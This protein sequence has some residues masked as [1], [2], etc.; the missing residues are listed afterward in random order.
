[1]APGKATLA[2]VTGILQSDGGYIHSDGDANWW[3]PSGR[4][5][6]SPEP[7]DSAAQELA[8]ARGHFFLPSRFED[9][10][11]NAATVGY[12]AHDL[13]PAQTND[14]LGNSVVAEIDYRVLQPRRMTDPNGNRS[15]VSFDA[16]GMVVGTAVIGKVG[17]S[18]GD[19]LDGFAPDLHEPNL[20]N[21]IDHPLADPHAILQGATMRLGYDLFAYQRTQNDPQ[22]QPALVYTLARET[23]VANLEPGEKSKIQHGF[24]YSDGF[25]REI[26]KKIQAEPGP[27]QD[28]GPTLSPRWVG[29]GWT[30]FN[31]KSKP[32]RQYEP[33]FSETHRFEFAHAVGVSPVLFYDPVGRVVATLS[34]NHTWGKVVF[35]PW[36]QEAWDRSDTVSIANP[37]TDADVGRYFERLPA[38]DYLPTWH[39]SRI[40]GTPEEQDAAKKAEAHAATPAVTHLDNLGRPFLTLADNGAA[41]KYVTRTEL[42]VEGNERDVIDA[43]G[44]IV[45]RYDYDVTGHNLHSASMEA[46]ASGRC[47]TS[48]A[49]P[50]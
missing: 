13:F 4:V 32:V 21:H 10:F 40:A 44:R 11:G 39:A 37:K 38:S 50:S 49:S 9:P 16:L 41:G 35:D 48:R 33:F 18:L 27:L 12:D 31:N 1:M 17:E 2:E 5:F 36:R 23:H 19:T 6:Y 22:P 14:A 26:Q 7:G 24:S 45:M 30:I 8:L 43:L 25:G 15:Q 42:D 3:V 34:P 29:S 46:G 28:G 20:L 47:T